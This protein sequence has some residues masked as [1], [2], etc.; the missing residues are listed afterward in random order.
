MDTGEQ[1]TQEQQQE[2]DPV[3]VDTTS[4]HLEETNHV[5]QAGLQAAQ[6]QEDISEQSPQQ[7]VV[8]LAEVDRDIEGNSPQNLTA[9]E[10]G[11]AGEVEAEG[12]WWDA[13]V[14]ERRQSGHVRVHYVGG[15]DEQ[16]APLAKSDDPVYIYLSFLLPI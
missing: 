6:D 10:Q 12:E 2:S 11:C 9:F 3:A 14:V 15:T 16:V 4:I 5:E 13:H 8:A 1:D 7:R